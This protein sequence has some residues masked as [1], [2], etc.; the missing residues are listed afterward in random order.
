MKLIQKQHSKVLYMILKPHMACLLQLT[1]QLFPIVNK[2]KANSL[3]KKDSLKNKELKLK[4]QEKDLQ[5]K[6][7]NVLYGKLIMH[8]LKKQGILYH[9]Y[10]LY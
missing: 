5:L 1:L 3:H 8:P 7:N 2:L 6:K 9:K 4:Q 10:F